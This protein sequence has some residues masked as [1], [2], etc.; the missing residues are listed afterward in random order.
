MVD[1]WLDDA[2]ANDLE[3]LADAVLDG[4]I[5]AAPSSGSVQLAGFGGGARAFLAHMQGTDPRVIAWMLRRLAHEKREA[6]DRF[7]TVA[8][9]VWSGASEDEGG[10]RDTRVVLDDLFGR[11][12]REVLLATYVIYDGATVF[13]SL[14][15][16]ARVVPSLKIEFF[17]NLPS[18]TGLPQDERPEVAD[19]LESFRRY[20]WPGDLAV[21]AIYYDPEGRRQGLDR[22]SLH[23]KCVVIDQRWSFIGSANFTGAAQE[24]NIETGVLLDHRPIAEALVRRFTALRE[25]GRLVHMVP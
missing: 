14:V 9:L 16:R 20:H 11:A 19:F 5:S 25:T 13:R 4:R 21:P 17:V 10:I 12:E 7:A 23:A 6:D 3:G 18:K 1:N 2:T 15:E 22:A 24:R 8:Q